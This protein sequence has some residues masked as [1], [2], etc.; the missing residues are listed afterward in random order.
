MPLGHMKIQIRI[1]GIGVSIIGIVHLQSDFWI[2]EFG[3][4]GLAG[5]FGRLPAAVQVTIATK[6]II[7]M[8]I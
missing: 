4:H 2:V 8:R 7:P 5:C 6:Q 1:C 3:L